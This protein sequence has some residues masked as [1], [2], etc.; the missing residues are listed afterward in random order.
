MDSQSHRVQ[1]QSQARRPRLALGSGLLPC[2]LLSSP[3]LVWGQCRPPQWPVHSCMAVL[4]V[5]DKDAGGQVPSLK[6]L[7]SQPLT[8]IHIVGPAL[9]PLL[10]PQWGPLCP[11][12]ASPFGIKILL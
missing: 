6:F 7:L 1:E 4:R 11:L 8:P 10:W 2:R 5:V 3:A 12:T 9:L